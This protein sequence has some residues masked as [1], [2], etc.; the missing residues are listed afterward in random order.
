[1]LALTGSMITRAS[2][3]NEQLTS[4]EIQLPSKEIQVKIA[5]ILRQYDLMIA[6]CKKQIALL[7]EAAQRLY[8][9][10]FVDIV[11]CPDL[12]AFKY[13]F[14]DCL[15][16][17]EDDGDFGIDSAYLLCERESVLLGHHHVK[18]TQVVLAL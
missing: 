17:K 16:C 9:E 13:V 15:G 11:V 7:E 3:R 10:W 12:E 2:L 8:R 18:H 1:M 14:L 6:N 5:N 4:I